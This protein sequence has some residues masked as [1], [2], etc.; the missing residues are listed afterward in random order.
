[1]YG[2]LFFNINSK[3]KELFELPAA[4]SYLPKWLIASGQVL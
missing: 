2:V 4:F 3:N 1:M